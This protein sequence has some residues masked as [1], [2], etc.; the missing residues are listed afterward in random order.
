MLVATLFGCLLLVV[1][2][3]RSVV[4]L[5]C[6]GMFGGGGCFSGF[7][8]LLCRGLRGQKQGSKKSEKWSS[9][10]GVLQN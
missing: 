6:V 2:V 4:W 8:L 5:Y 7:V 1:V 10:M 9:G 3:F